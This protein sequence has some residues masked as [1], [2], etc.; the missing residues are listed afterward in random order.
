M[1]LEF[2]LVG[3]LSGLLA[4]GRFKVFVLLPIELLALV[5]MSAQALSGR[6]MGMPVLGFVSF[7]L[8]LQAAYAARVATRA[9]TP[10]TA[11][12]ATHKA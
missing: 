9:R 3:L 5:V 6:G 10:R 7:S 4:G 1:V 12:F 11:P 2:A 8:C